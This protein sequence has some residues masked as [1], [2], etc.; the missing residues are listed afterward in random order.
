MNF[1]EIETFLMIVKTKNITKTAENLFLSQPTVS[2]RLKSLENELQMKLITRSKGYKSIELTAQGEEFVSIAERWSVLWKEMQVL[3]QTKERLYLTVGCT[4]TLSNT[5]LAPFYTQIF[6][7]EQQLDLKI[8]THQSEEIYGLLEKHE[9]DIGFVY[10]HLNFKNI[11]AEPV[12][13]EEMYIIQPWE[14][15]LRKKKISLKELNPEKEI[16]FSWETNYQIWHEQWAAG[17]I[18]PKI[19]IDSFG[20]ILNL[21]EGEGVWMIA[22]ASVVQTLAKYKKLQV[23]T[24]ADEIRP[25]KRITYRI[26]HRVPNRAK[27]PAVQKFEELMEAYLA[28]GGWSEYHEPEP[29]VLSGAE[30]APEVPETSGE[31]EAPKADREA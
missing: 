14:T 30:D 28:A 17:L 26:R 11:L 6:Q 1:A 10:H 23:S 7:N 13:A 31:R 25:P 21:L 5:I 16:F 24:V 3:Q 22:P 18:R 27:V 2:H 19:Q 20:L 4:D 8:Q 29:S 15:A 12:L 9:L